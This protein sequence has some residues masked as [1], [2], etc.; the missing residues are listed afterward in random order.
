MGEDIVATKLLFPRGHQINAYAMGALLSGGVFQ[1]EVYQKP[2]VL[3]IPT[4]SELVQWHETSPSQL[5][6]GQVIESNSTV[7]KALCR[8][9]GAD[10][11]RHPMLK[12]DLE[13]IIRAVDQAVKGAYYMVCIIG[14]SSAGSEDFC[15]TRDGF[16]G[17]GHGSRG[18]HDARQTGFDG[19][20]LR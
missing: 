15:K 19:R 2:R 13:T 4:G 16:P 18:D 9:N 8:D 14:G 6:P 12:D 1:V 17:P 11:D 5:V 10:A 20:Y 7:L 3:I